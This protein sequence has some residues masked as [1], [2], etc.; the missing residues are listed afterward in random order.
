M[1]T[2]HSVRRRSIAAF[3]ALIALAAA[4]ACDAATASSPTPEPKKGG[5]LYVNLQGGVD[6]LDPQRTYFVNDMNILRLTTRTLT[7]YKAV[8]GPEASEIVPDLATDTGRPSENNT[9]WKFSLKPGV[10]WEGGEPVTCSQVKYGIERRFSP[11]IDEGPTYPM[12]Y[13]V[14]NATPYQGPWLAGNNGGKGLESIV[15]LDERTIEFHLKQPVGD[16]GYTLAMATFAPVLPEKDTKDAYEQRPY[17]NGPYKIQKRDDNGIT[18]VRNNFWSESTDQVRKAY[19]DTIVIDYREDVGGVI[20]NE[21]IED[22]GKAR[23]TVMVDANVKSNFQQQV[24]NDPDLMKRVISGPAISTRWFAINMQHIPQIKCREALIYA[25][26]KRKWRAV[27]GGSLAGSFATTMIP[28][29]VKAHK[30]FDV[31]NTNANP[32]GDPERAAQLI[33]EQKDAGDPCKS[34][35]VIA[36]QDTQ[37]RRRLVATVVEAYAAAGIDV[38]TKPINVKDYYRTGVG[39]PYDAPD[40]SLVGWIPDWAN[41]SAILPPLFASSV[42]PPKNP[43]TGHAQGNV[44]W[45]MLQDPKI[46]QAMATALGETSPDRQWALWGALDEQIAKL[47]ITIPILNERTFRLAGSNVAGGYV[48]PAWNAPDIVSLGLADPSLG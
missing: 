30:D 43:V 45:S 2:P 31:F 19:P 25:F 40:L 24:A 14:D 29:G 37:D 23:N 48:H 13:L 7:T 34:P 21:L 27:A 20:T 44:N 18:L 4:S 3:L 33:K 42:I 17:S 28:P 15:C 9:V 41:G 32:D 22:Q 12:D 16:F 47:A 46:D 1:P 35:V 26:N 10:K 5:T 36:F 6:L 8:S 39:D 11:L 38:Q